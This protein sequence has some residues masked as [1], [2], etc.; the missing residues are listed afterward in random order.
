MVLLCICPL[1]L[2]FSMICAFKS[3]Y[4]SGDKETNTTKSKGEGGKARSEEWESIGKGGE[5]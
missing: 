3:K 2:Y 4:T 5:K 1:I